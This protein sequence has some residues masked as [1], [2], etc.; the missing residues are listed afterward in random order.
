MEDYLEKIEAISKLLQERTSVFPVRDS[1]Y[2]RLSAGLKS[3][4][5]ELI[6]NTD[7]DNF[8]H[9]SH[10]IANALK[11]SDTPVFICGS[12]KSG[13]T[14]L[15]HLLDSHPDLLVMPGDS[16]F[17]GLIAEWDRSQ[18]KEIASYWIHRI[19]NPTGQEP[20]WFFGREEKTFKLF[21]VYLD[22]FLRNSEKDVFVCVVMSFYVVHALLSNSSS[23]RY[24]VEK[25]PHNELHV[26]RLNQL[27]PKAKFIHVLREPLNNIAS[28]KKLDFY[29][30]WKGSALDHARVIN[31]LFKSAQVNFENLG[32]GKYLILKY[33]DLTKDPSSVM[34]RICAFLDISFDQILLTPTENGQPAVS[35]SMFH[36]DRVQ[37]EILN[38]E[39]N[40][41]YL[42]ELT[43]KELQDVVTTLYSEALKA[44]YRWDAKEI[45]Q[46]RKTG[47]SYF[48]H[49]VAEIL[50]RISQKIF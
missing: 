1:S 22:Y 43:K 8:K 44:G 26:Q 19:I 28:L 15:A 32:D 33:E 9:D 34:K 23:K 49:L 50:K 30:E 36:V 42:K 13:T 48:L 5:E 35:N 38:R 40:D 14:L 6:A 21:L 31:K 17:L 41:R 45:S 12:M 24:W 37:G 27:F 2:E 47:F 3:F 7:F 25:T 16:N 29:R 20:F 4:A 10:L 18:F 11:L 39:R 46:Y